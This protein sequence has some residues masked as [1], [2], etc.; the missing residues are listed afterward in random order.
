MILKN[1]LYTSRMNSQLEL[2]IWALYTVQWAHLDHN[3]KQIGKILSCSDEYW[4]VETWEPWLHPPPWTCSEST[5]SLELMLANY[6]C[7][8]YIL[9]HNVAVIIKLNIKLCFN[10]NTEIIQIERLFRINL[11]LR[12]VASSTDLICTVS[13][14]SLLYEWNKMGQI[15]QLR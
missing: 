13:N 10:T 8:L 12:Q 3:Y 15:S 9:S 5:Y 6:T 7:T 2:Q 1:T 4:V 14:H 11:H